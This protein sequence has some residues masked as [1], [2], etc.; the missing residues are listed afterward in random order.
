MMRLR[1]AL[2]CLALAS[3]VFC[4]C[5]RDHVEVTIEPKTDGSFV[6]TLRLWHTS[7]NKKGEI[8]P[9]PAALVD[10]AK[11]LYAK[12][13][14]TKDAAVAFQATFRTVPPD[15][16]A[17]NQTNRGGYT[18]WTSPLGQLGYYRERRPGRTD[19]F[20]RFREAADA[21]DLLMRYLTA[22]VRQQLEGEQ[23]L[24]RLVEFIDGPLR[25]DFKD[26]LYFVDHASL[27]AGAVFEGKEPAD[28]LARAAAFLAQ[29]AEER[30]YLQTEDIVK[31]RSEEGI[32]DLAT[33]VVA[34]KMGRPLDAQL[35]KKL[36]AFA[37]PERRAEAHKAALE[38]LKMTDEE[39]EQ[40]MKPITEGILHLGN[41]GDA[42][43]RYILALPPDAEL[44]YTSGHYDEK[45]RR[46][47]WE[48][49]LDDRPVMGI[50]FALWAVPNAD[51]QTKHLGRVAIHGEKLQDCILWENSL[52]PEHAASWRAALERL[53]PKRDV[54]DQLALIRRAPPDQELPE[55]GVQILIEAMK[56][57]PRP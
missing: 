32:L 27:R 7:G 52:A 30:D 46:I 42:D 9:P 20:T 21:A 11:P 31:F 34:R 28:T 22:I 2:G 16:Q 24:D 55:D 25:K 54:R 44:R 33:S 43:L 29:F 19:H 17:G 57:E 18:V 15:M 41:G 35:R 56:E 38:A 14:E 8:L 50:Y 37:E 49:T 12:A 23:G 13:L 10:Q 3:L 26:V 40:A 5:E 4:G 45:A 53:D 39:F 1:H 47:V 48:D 36:A 6:R 51:W